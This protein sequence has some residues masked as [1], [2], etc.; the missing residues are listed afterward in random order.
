M[1]K[2]YNANISCYANIAFYTGIKLKGGKDILVKGKEREREATHL[3]MGKGNLPQ[4]EEQKTKVEVGKCVGN[5][6]WE[7][8]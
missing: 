8:E 7:H 3:E 2:G 5:Y 1:N 6:H 4:M